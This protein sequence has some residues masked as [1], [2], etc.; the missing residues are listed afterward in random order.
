MPLIIFVRLTASCFNFVYAFHN[1]AFFCFVHWT[2]FRR[3]LDEE[4]ELS[5]VQP[6][7][8]PTEVREW[9]ATTFTRNTAQKQRTEEKP[10]FRSV[11]NAIRAG[12]MVD[13]L[14]RRICTSNM[15]QMSAKIV[16]KLKVNVL[17]LCNF[18]IL[19]KALLIFEEPPDNL[20]KVHL[21]L[22][23]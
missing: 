17:F 12:L 6:D 10:K 11:A 5:E 13:K 23:L 18:T 14:Y 21:R 9:L 16:E 8:V 20:S 2:H 4:D 19:I 15:V 3:L 7:A 1:F 22:F